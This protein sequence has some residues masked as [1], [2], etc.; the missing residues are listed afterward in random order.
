M[1]DLFFVSR[2]LTPGGYQTVVTSV[3]GSP[4]AL[5]CFSDVI[6][7]LADTLGT[8]DTGTDPRESL[9]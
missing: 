5:R 8:T 9:A 3:R 6:L 7:E 2:D 4:I 1:G